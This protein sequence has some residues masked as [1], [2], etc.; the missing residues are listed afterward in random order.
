MN[1]VGIDV[2]KG[3]STVAIVTQFGEL[4][5]SPFEVNHTDSELSELAGKLKSLKGETK[6]VM[7]CTGSYHLPVAGTLHAAGLTVYAVNPILIHDFGN[8][9]IRRR[10]NDK[11]DAMKIA[12]YTI[13]NWFE[14]PPEYVPEE[15]IRQ[16]LKTFSRQYSKYNKLKTSLTNNLISLLDRA[17]PGLNKLFTSGAREKD[18]HEK[19]I[20]FAGK[21]WHC[22]CVGE[23]GLKAFTE[24]YGKWC[25]RMGYYAVGA[26]EIHAAARNCVAVMPKSENTKSLITRAVVQVNAI[27]ETLSATA[28]EMNRLAEM[29]PE[30]PVVLELRGI[31][32]ILG[33]QLMAEVGDVRRFPKKSTLVAFAG[34]EPTDNESGDFHGDE[35]IS[36]KGSPHL[37]KTLFQ[38]M[39]C[40]LRTSPKDD[41]IYRLLDRKRAEG[42]HYYS[43]MCAGSAKLL[44]IYY[45]RVKSHL[46]KRDAGQNNLGMGC[47]L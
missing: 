14:L 13:T 40:L 9:T 29:L 26:D 32:K 30:Y 12:R 38:V 31:G 15:E 11:A 33:P 8:N 2:S 22:D 3:R 1:A 44:R 18:G 27:A 19:W 39:D 46:N 5:A 10:V 6:I 20:D 43:Y 28:F 36:K 37:R 7:E 42:K 34:L 35:K 47:T 17:F 41:I 25:K 16:M 21:F 23:T 45:A 4:V 24:R